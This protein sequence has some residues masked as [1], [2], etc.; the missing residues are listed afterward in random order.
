MRSLRRSPV[1]AVI[2][3]VSLAL[4]IGA[5]T[6]IF[7]IVNSLLLRP[8]PVA[9]PD[10]LVELYVGDLNHPYETC[11]YPSYTEL[12]DIN[13]VFTGLAAYSLRQFT[14]TDERHAEQ[15]WGEAVSGNYFDVL[16]L[17]TANGRMLV[18]DDDR[19]SAGN[20]VAVIS[21]GLW[22]RR[23]NADPNLIGRTIAIN[24]HSLTVVG[25]AGPRYTGMLRGLATE[26]WIPLNV[27][28]VV[29][30][31]RPRI[32][33]RDSRWL[34][35]VG[36]L[37]S[38]TTF[39]RV[40]AR[41]SLLSREMQQRRP[42]E[43]RWLRPETGTVRELFV[44]VF[45]ERD[46]RVH[47]SLREAAY[48]VVALLVALVNLVLLVACMNLASMLLVR[49]AARRKEIAVRL[50]LGASRSRLIRQLIIE[51][52]LLAMVAGVI[53]VVLTAWM[54][55]ALVTFMPSFPEGI[56]VALDLRMDW[57]VLAYTIVFSTLTGVLF[58]LA[59]ALR[60]SR[61]DLSSTLNNDASAIVG[62][63]RQSRTRRVL[64]V[65]QISLSVL[66]LV[67]AGL[68]LRSLDNIR[69]TRL[70]FDSDNFL[71]VPLSLD[72]TRY[73]RRS[74]QDFYRQL[75]DRV[76]TLPGVRRSSFVQD[77][78]GGFMGRTRRSTE[79]EGYSPG[80][81]E[82]L[83][84]DSS[85]VGPHYFTDMNVP[86]IR[87]R[88]F[89]DA[90]RDGAPCVA[91]VNEAFA[92]RYFGTITGAIGKHVA[93]F[94]TESVPSKQMCAVVGVVRDDRWQSL[95]KNV[96]PFFALPL[97]QSFGRRISLLVHTE[98]DPAALTN[99]IRHA[100]QQ[101][102][103][104]VPVQDVRTLREHFDASAYPFRLLGI[105]TSACGFMALFLAT[106]GVYGLVSYAAAQR[107]REIGIRMALGAVPRDVL[108]M[109]MGHGIV[110]VGCG[111]SLGL[112]LSLVL[113]RV[114]TS[115]VFETDLL[116]GVSPT[117]AA[118][119]TVSRCYSVPSRCSRA[120]FRRGGPRGS[121]RSS[122]FVTIS[123]SN[124]R[125]PGKG[126]STSQENIHGGRTLGSFDAARVVRRPSTVTFRDAP[127]EDS[128]RSAH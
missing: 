53:G 121:I 84:I 13:D 126:R 70:G 1:F 123:R 63:H 94:S 7:S 88:D 22:R 69:P 99:L 8:R 85:I 117:D 125:A 30:P 62:G 86:V 31:S 127:R 115:A 113:T 108:T 128:Y 55:G 16:G 4:G 91:I 33:T 68:L 58:G 49:A 95:E 38:D 27:M 120:T 5:N 93:A 102:D 54:L 92:E 80:P 25:I 124:R 87:G 109:V 10:E 2:A 114:L 39:D 14:L 3:V 42:E 107:T 76:S 35:L 47:P 101:L 20:P 26:V 67:A 56:R 111:I 90:D 106:V 119:F 43:W 19:Q 12:R 71:L 96:H 57:R 28:P 73:D 66:L 24:S 61:T 46:T 15:V 9:N 72:L 78:P 18:A 37:K 52:V 122:P 89:T 65:S 11:S 77:I 51:S 98:T 6:A 34:M 48:A 32:L 116:F 60:S 29:E 44:S 110:L 50:A 97:Y 100:I 45:R 82:R 103:S 41:F 112:F 81:A 17:S 21:D 36:R 105:V 74:S 40:R 83:E 104:T 79:I 75:S 23:Y 118:T 59:P 64:V